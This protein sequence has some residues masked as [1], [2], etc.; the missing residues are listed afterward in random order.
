VVGVLSMKALAAE[1]VAF[2]I[3]IDTAREVIEE[4]GR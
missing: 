1:N 3:P 2:V 4:L